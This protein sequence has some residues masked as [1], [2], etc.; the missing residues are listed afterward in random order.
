MVTVRGFREGDEPF[1]VE[2][3]QKNHQYGSPSVDGPEAMRRVAQN[4]AAAFLV[5]VEGDVPVG[6]VRGVYDGS[7]AMIHQLSVYPE[8]QREGIG[9]RLVREISQEFARRGAPTVSATVTSNSIAFWE[10]IGFERL[11]VF[12]ALGDIK[13]VAKT[14]LHD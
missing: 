11:E 5:A 2:I 7:R 9:T 10:R 3:L 13:T 4:S 6:F 12:L 1:L 8:Q 14:G